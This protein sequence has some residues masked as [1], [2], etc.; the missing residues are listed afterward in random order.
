MTI[1]ST[2]VDKNP[3][4][5]M[6]QSSESKKK[7]KLKCIAWV[8]PQNRQNYLGCFTRQTNQHHN[9]PSNAL[10]SNAKEA[11]VD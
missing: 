5:E 10:T 3:L 9:D 7:K 1:I 2:S 11:E 6:E 8:Q 4:E